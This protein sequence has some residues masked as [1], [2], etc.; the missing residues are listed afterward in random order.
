MNE[1]KE[2]SLGPTLSV[3]E[4]FFKQMF[5]KEHVYQAGSASSLRWLWW[6]LGTHLL[7]PPP[8]LLL[9]L[10]ALLALSQ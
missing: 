8:L 7:Q 1:W 2:G 9:L 4:G 3:S 5:F 10:N 6:H